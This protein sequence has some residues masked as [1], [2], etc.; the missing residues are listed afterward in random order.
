MPRTKSG[1]PALVRTTFIVKRTVLP[2]AE[3]E[4]SHSPELASGSPPN[5]RGPRR[6]RGRTP[7]P[8]RGGRG[9][10]RRRPPGQAPARMARWPDPREVEV[11]R[12]VARGMSNKRRSPSRRRRGDDRCARHRAATDH[13][14]QRRGDHRDDRR[15]SKPRGRPRD[16]QQHRRRRVQPRRAELRNVPTDAGRQPE[17]T[18]PDPDAAARFFA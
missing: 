17:A 4:S 6:G 8:R 18:E 9:A 2:A 3:S 5:D 10:R 13:R 14:F 7:R 12:L 11:L 1:H 16:R 15:D